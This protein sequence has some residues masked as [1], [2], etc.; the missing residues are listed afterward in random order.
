[1]E[2]VGN[3]QKPILHFEGKAK[4][5]VL[6][7]TN[8]NKLAEIFGDD[9]D[10]WAGGEIILYEAMVEF[11]GRTVPGLRVR[12]APRRAQAPAH[13]GNVGRINS[14]P[15]NEQ[16]RQS[17]MVPETNRKQTTAEIINDDIPF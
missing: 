8:A 13:N 14:Q 6:N 2:T 15:I 4:G 11:Q 7:K 16:G 5:M 3:D 17:A 1:M 12:I 10:N 9:T